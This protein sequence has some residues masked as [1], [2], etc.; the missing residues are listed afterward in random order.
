MRALAI[1]GAP[2]TITLITTF[3]LISANKYPLPTW[4]INITGASTCLWLTAV[5][6]AIF[7]EAIRMARK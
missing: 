6:I 3:I 4:T 7:W 1:L 2:L 5:A